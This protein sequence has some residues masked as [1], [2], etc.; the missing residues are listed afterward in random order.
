MWTHYPLQNMVWRMRDEAWHL[1]PPSLWIWMYSVAIRQVSLPMFLLAASSASTMPPNSKSHLQTI[2]SPASLFRSNW[3]NHLLLLWHWMTFR[4][5]A[6]MS[7][8]TYGLSGFKMKDLLMRQSQRRSNSSRTY[9][10]PSHSCWKR[11]FSIQK[12]CRNC[13]SVRSRLNGAHFC[14]WWDTLCSA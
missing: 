4:K 13:R 11:H 3:L 6:S 5:V 14:C 1:P 8:K 2:A 7:K 12:Y 9:S 10:I